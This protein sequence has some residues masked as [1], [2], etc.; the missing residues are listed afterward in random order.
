MSPPSEVKVSA[1]MS[2][3]KRKTRPESLDREHKDETEVDKDVD[4]LS[5]AENSKQEPASSSAET[6]ETIADN[7]FKAK[8]EVTERLVNLPPRPAK[9]GTDAVPAQDDLQ[10]WIK[11]KDHYGGCL[12]CDADH[13]P[14]HNKTRTSKDSQR[15]HLIDRVHFGK[16][17]E[18]LIANNILPAP[19]VPQPSISK[20]TFAGCSENIQ[21]GCHSDHSGFDRECNPE[22]IAIPVHLKELLST[23]ER[24]S[25]YGDMKFFQVSTCRFWEQLFPFLTL[26]LICVLRYDS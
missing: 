1:N 3:K 7:D 26:K 8:W 18:T 17:I 10:C 14:P 20:D 23:A 11:A 12:F 5:K 24:R 21:R 25:R 9:W 19:Q 2:N 16:D 6:K 4:R 22:C 13:F 15:M